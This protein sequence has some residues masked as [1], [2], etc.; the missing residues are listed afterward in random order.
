MQGQEKEANLQEMEKKGQLYKE[1]NYEE[2]QENLQ[3][4]LKCLFQHQSLFST[5]FNFSVDFS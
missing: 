2:M 1:E 5:I 3:I 4:M